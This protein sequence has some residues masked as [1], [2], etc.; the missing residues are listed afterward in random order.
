MLLR[1]A[2][3]AIEVCVGGPCMCRMHIVA[4]LSVMTNT[5]LFLLTYLYSLQ[6]L[7][8][9]NLLQLTG[10]TDIFQ[11]GF[12]TTRQFCY[13]TMKPL[14]CY[15]NITLLLHRFVQIIF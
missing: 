4:V 2:E 15:R 11:P 10:S 8:Q 6:S 7:C 3:T 12:L 14:C 9:Y 13:E 5:T 1:Y